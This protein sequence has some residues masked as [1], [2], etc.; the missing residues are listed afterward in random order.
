M[1]I[2]ENFHEILADFLDA[3]LDQDKLFVLPQKLFS[4]VDEMQ[5][6]VEASAQHS[7]KN[8]DLICKYASPFLKE[9]SIEEL[10]QHASEWRQSKSNWR[11]YHMDYSV[12][13]WGP[14]SRVMDTINADFNP[15]FCLRY[16]QKLLLHGRRDATCR[17]IREEFLSEMDAELDRI[18]N[19]YRLMLDVIQTKLLMNDCAETC[20]EVSKG[21]HTLQSIGEKRFSRY[22]D[23]SE[24]DWNCPLFRNY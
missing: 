13:A 3:P 23:I 20:E 17:R 12:I 11:V 14:R 7:S 2:R 15:I 9:W 8:H 10:D 16:L 24:G 21:L 22:S 1:K 5:L 18:H 19:H 4:C 6:I